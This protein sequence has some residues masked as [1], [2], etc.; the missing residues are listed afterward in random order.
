MAVTHT[1]T[2]SNQGRYTTFRFGD[3]L[4]R[5]IAPEPLE[6]YVEVTEWDRGYLVVMT[7]YSVCDE[8]VEE[9]IDLVPVLESLYMDPEEFCAPIERVEVAHA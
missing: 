9:Y 6:R 4:L 5:F 8:P 2:L 1:A 3:T 7:K